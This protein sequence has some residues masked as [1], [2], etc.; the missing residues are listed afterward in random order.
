VTPLPRG[1]GLARRLRPFSPEPAPVSAEISRSVLAAVSQAIGVSSR[2]SLNETH[3][4]SAI[5]ALTAEL[6][7]PPIVDAAPDNTPDVA[8]MQNRYPLLRHTL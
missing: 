5:D 4:I 1:E 8:A 3:A 2:A 7:L 6:N